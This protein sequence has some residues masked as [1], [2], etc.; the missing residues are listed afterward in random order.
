[1]FLTECVSTTRAKMIFK[2]LFLFFSAAF[3]IAR[4]ELSELRHLP[5]ILFKTP[6]L[7]NLI[8]EDQALILLAFSVVNGTLQVI[9]PYRVSCTVRY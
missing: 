9:Q 3:L 5:N 7:D 8:C 6:Y 4:S 2:A 1:M